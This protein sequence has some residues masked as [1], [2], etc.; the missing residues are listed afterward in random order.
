MPTKIIFGFPFLEGLN[1]EVE[2]FGSKAFIVI[3][4][5]FVS[6]IN[7]LEKIIELLEKKEDQSC[8]F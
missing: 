8:I 5:K 1:K 2:N 7:L 6:E 4:K 3:D